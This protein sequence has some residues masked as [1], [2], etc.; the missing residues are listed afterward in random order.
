M[1]GLFPSQEAETPGV[2]K[3]RRRSP[4][5]RSNVDPPAPLKKEDMKGED[6]WSSKRASLGSREKKSRKD[7]KRAAIF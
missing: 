6:L 3:K 5:K 7:G 4:R 1:Q 2:K